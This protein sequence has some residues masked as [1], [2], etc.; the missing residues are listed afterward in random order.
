MC[1]MCTLHLLCE[2]ILIFKTG[3]GAGD[4]SIGA[5]TDSGRDVLA[6]Q[7]YW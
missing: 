3:V 6:R 1:K 4:S 2:Q 5:T 7:A